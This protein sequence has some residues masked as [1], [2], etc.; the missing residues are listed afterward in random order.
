MYSKKIKPEKII[1]SYIFWSIFVLGL[2][3][4]TVLNTYFERGDF[5]ITVPGRH[6]NSYI[7]AN[8]FLLLFLI[9][10]FFYV[11]IGIH[12]FLKGIG[13]RGFSFLW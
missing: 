9:I 2:Y 11:S 10:S 4:Y 6:T 8:E 5:C 12:L 3:I 1:W 13:K 7:C